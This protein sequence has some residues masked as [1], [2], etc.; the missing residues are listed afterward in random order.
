MFYLQTILQKT[1]Q[2]SSQRANQTTHSSIDYARIEYE[3]CSIEFQWSTFQ[4]SLFLNLSWKRCTN[5]YY[6]PCEIVNILQKQAQECSENV[7]QKF[8][9]CKLLQI[10]YSRLI[11]NYCSRYISTLC[12]EVYFCLKNF[13]FK[14]VWILK[15]V[16]WF[17]REERDNS[18]QSKHDISDNGNTAEIDGEF[19]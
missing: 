14:M 19:L 6:S 9:Q 5:F 1:G 17:H 15:I 11:H 16:L 3:W 12:A 10:R 2:T 8:F 4:M 13:N 18:L 7:W